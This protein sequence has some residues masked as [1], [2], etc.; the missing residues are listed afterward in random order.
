M[1]KVLLG[2]GLVVALTG[3]KMLQSAQTR[4]EDSAGKFLATTAVTVDNTMTA[5]AKWVVMGKATPESEAKVRAWYGNY[6]VAM[7]KATNAYTVALTVKTPALFTE[8]SNALFSAK[9]DLLTAAAI[10]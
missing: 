6:Q 3:C 9:V 4:F 10:H 7:M 8:S 2:L 5:W 1:K